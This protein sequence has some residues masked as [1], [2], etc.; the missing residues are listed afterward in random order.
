M[1]KESTMIHRRTYQESIGKSRNIFVEMNVL[2]PESQSKQEYWSLHLNIWPI[3]LTA[4]LSTV[5]GRVSGRNVG[6]VAC[7]EP[8]LGNDRETNETTA[9]ARQRP[10]HN[11]G[12]T[13]GSY[14]SYVGRSEAI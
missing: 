4:T 11:N 10:A 5:I 13:V 2:R 9:V 3:G 8:L 1:W 12:S 7:R 14:F 6:I